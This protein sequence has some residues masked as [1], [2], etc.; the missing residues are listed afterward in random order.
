MLHGGHSGSLVPL[1]T[2][3]S[4]SSLS[5]R[6]AS[7]RMSGPE[8]LCCTVSCDVASNNYPAPSQGRSIG[9]WSGDGGGG[10]DD[11]GGGGGSGRDHGEVALPA[12]LAGVVLS[13]STP[14]ASPFARCF[15]CKV[16]PEFSF[17]LLFIDRRE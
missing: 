11:A 1:Y 7:L 10:D 6:H 16:G 14:V 17:S 13:C 12:C 9:G 2:H 4:V 8:V 5:A 15:N 3:G